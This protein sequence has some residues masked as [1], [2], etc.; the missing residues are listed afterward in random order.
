MLSLSKHLNQKKMKQIKILLIFVFLF[1]EAL[2]AQVTFIVND[3]PDNH[4]FN[5]SVYISGSFEGWSGGREELQLKKVDNTY[6]ITL[7]DIPCNILY[8]FTLGSWASVEMD[9]D[10]VSI[11]NRTY[12]CEE[13]EKTIYISIGSWTGDIENV[14]R[15]TAHKNV[16]VLSEEFEIPQL[17]TTRK[18]SIYLP[19]NYQ[20]SNESFP[21]IY[22]HDGQNIF[23]IKTSYAGEWEVD[24]TLNKLYYDTNFSAIVVAVDH[25]EEQRTSEYIPYN[26][27]RLENTKGKDYAR[28]LV[29]TLKPY[30]DEN[31][32]TLKDKNNTAIIGSSLG[33]L[34]SHYAAL[35][36]PSVFGKAGVFSPS[37]WV[38]EE[39]YDL[40]KQKSKQANNRMYFLMGGR[41]SE[42][43][44]P[45]M[46]RM[47]NLM[48]DSGYS[49]NNIYRKVVDEGQ[50]NE[51][52]WRENFEEAICWLFDFTKPIRTFVSAEEIENGVLVKVSDGEYHIKF[53]SDEI[54]ETTFVPNGEELIED[55]HAVVKKTEEVELIPIIGG[56]KT[57]FYSDGI[58][59]EITREPFQIEYYHYSHLITSEKRG[60]HKTE[61]GEAISLNLTEDEILYGGG[62]RALGMNRRGNRLQLYNKAHYGYE[63]RSLLM[64]Y[65]MPIVVSSNQYMIHF[66]NA[67]IGY[68]DLDSKGDNTLTY[69]TIS[70]RKTYQVIVGDTWEDL[71]DNYT[72]LTGKQPMPPR[73]ALGNFS[74][75]FGYHSQTETERTIDAFKQENIPVDAIILDLYW[76]GKD[77][78]GTMGN[79]EVYKDSF[80]DF[81]AMTSNL[82]QKG[83]KTVVI[84]EPFVLTTSNRWD[85]AV[86]E[87]I[88]AKDSLGNPYTYDFF[89]GNTGLIDIYNPKAEKWFWNIYKDI[90]NLGVEGVWGDLGEPEV[91]PS[92]LLHYT[93]T[94]DEVHNI[95][96]HDWARLVYEGYAK[97]FPN[98]RPFILMR[99]GYS[100]TQRYGM[101][102]W[103]GDV[104]RTWGGMRS[105]PEIALQMGMQGLGYMHSDL[106]GFAGPNLDDELYTRWLQYGVFNP[107]YR[108]HAQE[109]V[110]SEPVF[111]EENTKHLAKESIE[112]R[113]KLLPYNYNLA[114][115]NNQKGLPL[116]RPLFFE[117]INV[118]LY[119]NSS[120]YL[121]GNDFLITPILN[122][123]ANKAEVY[124]P[125]TNHWFDFYTDKKVLGGQTKFV[126]TKTNSIPTFVRAGAFI[127][128]AKLVQSTDDYTFNNFDL[129]YYYD[130][131]VK[132]SERRFYN[133]DGL[134]KEAFEKGNYEILEFEF[135]LDQEDMTFEF[136]AEIGENYQSEI[137]QFNL[138]IHNIESE[139]KQIKFGK[140]RIKDFSYNQESKIVS[141]P[142]TWNTSK[143]K[144]LTIK[145]K[146]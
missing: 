109:D 68:L 36:Y 86:K 16:Q 135:E 87:D 132:K 141:I 89:F 110:A 20:D 128:M 33:G 49:I 96:G 14:V 85:E 67:P 80:P 53:Y 26:F 94:A 82:K 37:F 62:A 56:N 41:E 76:F 138:I 103:S 71:I 136:E 43:A 131:S 40:A 10:G 47:I 45:N 130:V 126:E 63:E 74:S 98:Q 39:A 77:V 31:F 146:K 50:H 90:A 23:D 114:F 25:G 48:K 73:W 3:L 102:P 117:E 123:E 30:I 32:K 38:S 27:P 91:H 111:R 104:N 4:D 144:E 124:F 1:T 15:S 13:G 122:S 69:E 81:K 140:K 46:D 28:F 143:E 57:S 58:G 22:M 8:K 116:M 17:N 6:Q 55:S 59:I 93:G 54:V 99:A 125:K 127:P 51:Q 97:D 42:K 108:P 105:Q 7:T 106:G 137:K 66:D 44:V 118:E 115:E 112:L 65:T 79:L 88:L 84:T 78:Q 29:E 145:L 107:I 70:G 12:S 101:M 9:T 24:E 18:I 121:W 75:R 34:I 72:D 139:P 35:E 120:T 134:T 119:T 113:Y 61:V 92:E 60:Y 133:D 129:H 19:P 100:G 52:L 11:E 64:N 142:L 83:V 21:V 95:Y 2:S 5:A